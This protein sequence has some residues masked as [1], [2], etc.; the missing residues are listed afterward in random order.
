MEA[1]IAD[2]RVKVRWDRRNCHRAGVRL[3]GRRARLHH[4]Q[5]TL[6][7]RGDERHRTARVRRCRIRKRLAEASRPAAVL[8]Q[9]GERS[10]A[11]RLVKIAQQSKIPVVGV[12]ET[13][14]P[15]K[16]YQDWMMGELDAVVTGPRQACI[17]SAVELTGATLGLRCPDRACRHRPCDPRQRVRRRAR[18]ERLGQDHADAR[19]PRAAATAQRDDPRAGPTGRA[20]QSGRRLH[21]ADAR[22]A[23]T[24]C[25]SAAGT[26]S[27]AAPTAIA[28]ACRCSVPTRA[29]RCEWALDMVDAAATSRDA[30]WPRPPAASDSVCCW[31]RPCSAARACCCWMNR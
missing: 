17:V 5:R 14:P 15:G 6:P 25:G 13:E 10:A 22:R 11:Q 20:R 12:T 1:K 26:S 28:G 21:A 7:A 9:P 23:R 30:R 29:A 4:A 16:T 2:L 31:R 24:I 19:D 27:P 18:S 3:Y 8:Q